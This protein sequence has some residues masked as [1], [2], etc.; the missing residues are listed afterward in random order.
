ME[1]RVL[2]YFLAV[3]TAGNITK[4]ARQLHLTQPTLSRQLADLEAELGVQLFVRGHQQITLTSEGEYLRARAS[5]L[6]DLAEQ[7]TANLQAGRAIS[8][9]LSIG[10]GESSGMARITRVIGELQADHPDVRFNLISGNASET[11]AAL[12]HGTI[13]FAVIMGERPLQQYHTLQLPDRDR[14]GVVMKKDD[15]LTRQAAIP[16]SALVDRPLIMS[17]QG[18]SSDHFLTWWGSDRERL[19][20]IGTY[21]LVF[22][23]Q[24]LVSQ[25]AGYLITYAG[26]LNNANQAALTFRPLTPTLSEPITLIWKKN[27]VLSPVARLFLRRLRQQIAHEKTSHQPEADNR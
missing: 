13:D 26:L 6:V 1:I 25:G 22:N 15:P 2:R 14:W 12:L 27:T 16:A 17:R 8:G 10:A 23:A 5:E 4:A 20:V 24:L 19:K 7:T 11:E 18:M 9:T 21:S 3:V